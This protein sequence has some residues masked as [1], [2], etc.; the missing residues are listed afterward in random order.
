MDPFSE[1]LLVCLQTAM[2]VHVQHG[3]NAGSGWTVGR[4]EILDM[5]DPRGYGPIDK[6]N[7]RARMASV[8]EQQ[9]VHR[10]CMEPAHCN[11]T[12]P[13]LTPFELPSCFHTTEM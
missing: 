4:K 6:S 9:L 8:P 3:W 12:G 5:R 7:L 11:C 10:F 2:G 1:E 13:G